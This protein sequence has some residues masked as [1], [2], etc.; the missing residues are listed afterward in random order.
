MQD[1]AAT[2]LTGNLTEEW[3]RCSQPRVVREGGW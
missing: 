1:T 2:T 3:T